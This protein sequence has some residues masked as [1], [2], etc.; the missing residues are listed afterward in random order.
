VAVIDAVTGEGNLA[1]APEARQQ[2][3]L[4]DR[5]VL[6]KTDLADA[7]MRE[8]LAAVIASLGTAPVAIAA[9]GEIEPSF[10]LDDPLVQPGPRDFAAAPHAHT[11]GL[12]SFSLIFAEPLAWPGFQQAMAVLTALRG[13]DLLRVKG[14]VSIRECRGPVVV[15]YVQHLAHSPVELTDWPD[16]DRRSRLVFITRNLPREP[17]LQLFAA[18]AAVEGR[19]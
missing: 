8:R 18:V 12:D 10:L 11:H 2:V 5:I 6:T 13:P 3:A 16:D 19:P 15:H 4:A 1:R 14:L 9:H 17:V 7:G